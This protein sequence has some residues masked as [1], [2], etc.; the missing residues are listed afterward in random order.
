M[1]AGRFPENRRRPRDSFRD[2]PAIA[3]C[4]EL[5]M[6]RTLYAGIDIGATNIKYGLV[7]SE[8]SVCIRNQI[9]TPKNGSAEELFE[10]VAYCG[11]QLLIEADEAS[12]TVDFIGVGSPGSVSMTSGIIQGTCPNIP[13]WVGFH[14]RD[15]LADRLNLP[16]LVDNDANCAAIAEHRFG[17]GRG[18]DN[19][20][21]LTVGTG[22]GGGLIL[23]GKIYRGANDSAGE[24]GHMIV[25]DDQSGEPHGRIL[26]SLVSSRAI[27]AR[28]RA[29]L[30]PGI[31]PVFRNIIGDDIEQLTMRKLFSAV[32]RGD[33]AALTVIQS[34][35]R[36][37]G[38]A[39]A[40]LVNVLNPELV[41]IGGG[42]AEGGS[43]FVDTVR[44]TVLK[45]ALP[46]A[47]DDLQIVPAE[48]GNAAGFIG[49]AMLGLEITQPVE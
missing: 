14:L 8:G 40:S 16:A 33:T 44:D 24:I 34:T 26:E 45:E 47:N 7:D 49:A 2:S 39:L 11:E 5:N 37:L 36:L 21:C 42:V 15:R 20:V 9:P 3:A 4:H 41:I 30:E 46:T 25:T 31:T 28:M 43:E 48:L 13:G 1:T 12:A 17:A 29:V 32:R 10:K 6:S 18:Y 22:I 38:R 23:N 27:L 35:A 19:V